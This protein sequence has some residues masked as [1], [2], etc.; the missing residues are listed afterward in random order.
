MAGP[1]PIYEISVFLASN[2]AEEREDAL[3][4]STRAAPLQPCQHRDGALIDGDRQV[5]EGSIA[6]DRD[7]GVQ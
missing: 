6:I 7:S 3:G 2:C 1:T 4:L 5:T